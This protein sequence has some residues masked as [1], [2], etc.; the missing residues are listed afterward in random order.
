MCIRDRDDGLGFNS[1]EKLLQPGG[2]GLNNI[3]NKVKTINGL[4]LIKSKP[5]EGMSVLVSFY[6]K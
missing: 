3:I 4:S 2:H 5:G 6:I 1:E